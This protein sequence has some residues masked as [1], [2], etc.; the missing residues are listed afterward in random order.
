MGTS[1]PRCGVAMA[2]AYVSGADILLKVGT[3]EKERCGGFL[4][5]CGSGV[6]NC[7]Q[8]VYRGGKG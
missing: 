4:I 3:R 6:V 8:W 1:P 5:V 7:M 2:M